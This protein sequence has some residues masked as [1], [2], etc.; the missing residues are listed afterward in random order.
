[1][2]T[3]SDKDLG[4]DCDFVARGNTDQEAIEAATAHVRDEHP[5]EAER[6]LAAMRSKIRNE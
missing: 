4:I 2:K 5:E 3:I 1:M 6:A